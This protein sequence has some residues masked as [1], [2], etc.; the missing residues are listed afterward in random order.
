M[1][2]D[3]D[4]H[5]F[6]ETYERYA[7][8]WRWKAPKMAANAFLFFTRDLQGEVDK[9]ARAI[10]EIP[11]PIPARG[12]DRAGNENQDAKEMPA[13]DKEAPG[14]PNHWT[15][16]SAWITEQFASD[17]LDTGVYDVMA[18]LD[19]PSARM[20]ED[21]KIPDFRRRFNRIIDGVRRSVK[22][23]N[24]KFS[25]QGDIAH[26][27]TDKMLTHKFVS[28]LNRHY[29]KTAR[30]HFVGKPAS[31]IQA[32]AQVLMTHD[33]IKVEEQHA[34]GSPAPRLRVPIAA[35]E[36]KKVKK[37]VPL[38]DMIRKQVVMA[39]EIL[40]PP[41]TQEEKIAKAVNESI[42]EHL[43]QTTPTNAATVQPPKHT[44]SPERDRR[45][46]QNGAPR[47]LPRTSPRKR[48]RSPDGTDRLD[49][50][51]RRR[52]DDRGAHGRRH[53]ERRYDGRQG[54]TRDPPRSNK[55]P[56]DP[57]PMC[58]GSHFAYKCE[59]YCARCAERKYRYR[60][61]CVAT[62]NTQ[63]PHCQKFGHTENA[64]WSKK[65]GLRPAATPRTPMP[66]RGNAHP[67]GSDPRPPPYLK[68]MM[69]ELQVNMCATLQRLQDERIDKI[70]SEHKLS[71]EEATDHAIAHS[72]P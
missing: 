27:P 10:E 63:C 2:T 43:R 60:E 46:W 66:R 67:D 68:S 16:L 58:G 3:K 37:E 50:R 48:D 45:H 23:Y 52:T 19:S 14:T 59:R 31:S 15:L 42:Q 28:L 35:A 22:R 32:V 57:C 12:V 36:V 9:K 71:R 47:S 53:G 49:R 11:P 39:M 8:S 40:H 38:E 21:E 20:R 7:R 44:R 1:D 72:S 65:R 61:D 56:P 55:R 18:A 33:K 62:K 25:E 24:E 54:E 5:V 29:F 26:P 17:G 70:V 34:F 6:L 30:S 4:V 41:L 13:E 69:K 64:C 51:Q